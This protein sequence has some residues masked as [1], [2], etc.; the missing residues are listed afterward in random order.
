MIA[1]FVLGLAVYFDNGQGIEGAILQGIKATVDILQELD[2]QQE[3]EGVGR[4]RCD[5]MNDVHSGRGYIVDGQCGAFLIIDREGTVDKVHLQAGGY[6]F[7]MRGACRCSDGAARYKGR[8]GDGE[9]ASHPVDG[10]TVRRKERSRQLTIT[11][12]IEVG[13]QR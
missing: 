2:T 11:I 5:V 10:A 13:E 4:G 8:D 6:K 7:Y 12:K 1:P 9:V 3:E